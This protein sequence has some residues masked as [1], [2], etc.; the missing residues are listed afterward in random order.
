MFNYRN[1]PR[2]G[3]SWS[4]WYCN[5]AQHELCRPSRGRLRPRRPA[6][7]VQS[8]TARVVPGVARPLATA[9]AGT[10]SAVP[11]CSINHNSADHMSGH[12]LFYHDDKFTKSKG[13]LRFRRL[14]PLFVPIGVCVTTHDDRTASDA[15]VGMWRHSQQTTNHARNGKPWFSPP[16]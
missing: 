1:W 16:K 12:I 14:V 15:T 8:G 7:R 10:T 6:Q 5:P 4:G 11:D 9:P 13:N 3:L 2:Y